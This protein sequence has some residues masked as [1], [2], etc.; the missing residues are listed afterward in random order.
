MPSRRLST[1]PTTTEWLT[2]DEAAARMRCSTRT[3]HRRIQAGTAQAQR[4]SDGRTLVEV[5][6]CP[7][8]VDVP[9]LVQQLAQ[10]AA[11]TNRVAALAAMTA[12][13]SAIGYRDRLSVVEAAL[14]DERQAAQTWRKAS[15]VCAAVCLVSFGVAIYMAAVNTA[16]GRHASDAADSL[17]NAKQAANGLLAA[18]EAMTE[19]RQSSDA[20]CAALVEQ[21]A[22]LRAQ[23]N[24]LS[25]DWRAPLLARE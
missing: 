4:R 12:E 5:E 3:L 10:Q 25:D 23:R 22:E 1:M 15:A 20:T 8:P 2:I 17:L 11:D 7:T 14:T 13:Q 9:E 6:A 24:A 18:L 21:V 19:A 16:T